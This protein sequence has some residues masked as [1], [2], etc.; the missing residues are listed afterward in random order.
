MTILINGS[1]LTCNDI[2]HVARNSE[3]VALDSAVKSKINNS[4]EVVEKYAKENKVAYGIT[5]GVGKLC[6]EL[7]SREQAA[8]LQKNISLSHACGVGE[9]LSEEETRAIMITRVNMLSVGYS[10]ISPN[11]VEMLVSMLNEG[12]SPVLPRKG[13]VGSSGSLSIGAYIAQCISGIGNVMME[14]AKVHAGEALHK[15]GLTPLV[16]QT[17]D[18]L[19]LI[20]GT[21][22]MCGIGS[23]AIHDL[24]L[25]IKASEIA[26]S[27]SLEALYGNTAAFDK[28]INEAKCHPGQQVV[29]RNIIRMIE[30]S[31]LYKLKPRSVQD[32]YS[33][34]CLPQVNGG[35]RDLLD[36]AQL[37]IEREIN[38]ASDNPL[39]FAD[40][41]VIL[42]CGNF[43][44]EIPA[45]ALD[46]TAIACAVIAN[47]SERRISRMVDPQ[48]S[49]LPAFLT[50]NSG[51]NSGLMIPQYIAASLVSEIKLMANP[52][53]IDSIPTSGGQE[54][55]VSN[56]TIAA[57]KARTAVSNLQTIIGI[58]LLCAAQA[59]DLSGRQDLGRGTSAAYNCIR[60]HI[61]QL[62][63]DR[64]L[65]PDIMAATELVASGEIVKETEKHIGSLE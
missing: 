35:A 31:T 36:F 59:L 55:V 49:G 48:C 19:S 5:T 16:L 3:K 63:E 15:K 28:R 4:R 45:I 26:A 23:L 11:V 52:V 38:S 20:N 50:P 17:K 27:M 61:E 21:H 25:T 62:K 13:G 8:Q 40:D 60:Q 65:E 7:I 22:S 56:G 1:K 58:E 44:G 47:L 29:G 2:V 37:L 53:C 46:N 18:C 24:Y 57:N 64:F 41:D 42:S 12:I 14:G 33:Y 51:L 39:V 6:N 34:R 30:G 10:G 43:H 32:A 54:D 9:P